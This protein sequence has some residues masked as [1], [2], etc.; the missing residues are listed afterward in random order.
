MAFFQVCTR[1]A[2]NEIVLRQAPGVLGHDRWRELDQKA[3][4][5]LLRATVGALLPSATQLQLSMVSSALYG[6]L[7]ELSF[8]V[9]DNAWSADEGFV[10]ATRRESLEILDRV[11]GG[12][13]FA[14]G[15]IYGLLNEQPLSTAIEYAAAHGALAMT[16]PGDT[17]MAT[18]AE[19]ERLVNGGSA[20][21]V[22]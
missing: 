13:S 9:S 8:V 18:L 14:S 17:S 12:D 21:V 11:G 6:M 19:V 15:L 1:P 20:R 2:Y 16:T 3:F 10:E 5:G 7:T 4:A 22:R